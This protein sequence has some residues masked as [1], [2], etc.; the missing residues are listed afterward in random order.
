VEAARA[1]G[2]EIAGI[3]LC[4]FPAEPGLAEAT[5]PGEIDELAG[6]VPHLRGLDV[7]RAIVP[8]P[9]EPVPWLAPGLGG[10]FDAAAFVRSLARAGELV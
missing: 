5:N 9:F 2:L 6:V 7:D 10:T 4:G 1:R 8:S 3:V